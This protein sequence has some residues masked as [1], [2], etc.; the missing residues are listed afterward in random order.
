MNGVD[1][2][3]ITE[4]ATKHAF[5]WQV[6]WFAV[7][8]M[9]GGAAAFGLMLYLFDNCEIGVIPCMVV[10]ALLFGAIIGGALGF[11]FGIPVEYTNEYKVIISDEVNFNEFQEK[12]KIID[13]D[14]K[15]FTVRERAE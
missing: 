9:I 13:Q 8:I 2:L 10:V 1:I 6:F 11:S 4:I 7:L 3:T 5:N 14:G 12:Y 15:I